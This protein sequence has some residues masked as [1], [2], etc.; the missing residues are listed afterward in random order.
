MVKRSLTQ[1]SD[2]NPKTKYSN[3]KHWKTFLFSFTWLRR[4]YFANTRFSISSIW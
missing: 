2:N 4:D 3:G 1:Q